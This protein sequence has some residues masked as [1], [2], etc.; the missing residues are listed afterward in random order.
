MMLTWMAYAVSVSLILAVA[1]LCA[2]HLARRRRT[3]SRWYWLISLTT[4]LLM[5]TAVSS[6]SI[7][8]PQVLDSTVSQKAAAPQQVTSPHLSP[9]TWI[10]AP[11]APSTVETVD[12]MLKRG[13]CAASLAM[14]FILFVS[15][16]NLHSRKRKW[17]T[18]TVAGTPV[19][20]SENVGPAV[21]G[22]IRPRI[23]VPIWLTQ[24]SLAQQSAVI[25]HE[26]SHIAAGD[27]QLLAISLCLIVLMPWNLPLWWQLR[28]LRCAIEIDCDARV[29]NE[30]HDFTTYGETLIAVGERQ[31]RYI[32]S[33]VGMSESRSFLER[34]LRIMTSK[35]V[36]PRLITAVF[37][38]CSST[39]L[40]VFAAQVSP[41][42]MNQS[43]D[44]HQFI[45][46]AAEI[47]DRYVGTYKVNEIS[48]LTVTR[49]GEHL[50][51]TFT[52]ERTIENFSESE[53]QFYAPSVKGT[54]NFEVDQQGHVTGAVLHQFGDTLQMRRVDATSAQEINAFVADK[55]KN[56]TATPGSEAALRRL[57]EGLASGNP[58]YAE[59]S[60]RLADATREQLPRLKEGLDRL[61]ALQSL[62]FIGVG[63]KGWDVYQARFEHGFTIWRLALLS[64]GIIDGALVT[65]GP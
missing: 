15:A 10:D 65:S 33:V 54:I 4:S 3:A 62:Q 35:A 58:N 38:V 37:L 47:L 51:T 13:W 5:P 53:T 16:L 1:A 2:E 61:G 7:K 14:S 23:V 24:S 49:D 9:F 18:A 17:E 48:V 56:Q 41:P 60:A 64:N 12:A 21:V 6:I 45:H 55:I 34:R 50:M 8:V 57:I 25:S 31:S 30:G 63:S 22:L 46:V 52:G 32:G 36:K 19:Y 20:L 44:D 28:R 26:K 59:Q 40:V 29:L 42:I 11:M 27:P 43:S 39:A